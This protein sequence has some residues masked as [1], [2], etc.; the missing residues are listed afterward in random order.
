VLLITNISADSLAQEGDTFWLEYGTTSHMGLGSG[1]DYD[2]NAIEE[3]QIAGQ[4]E[5][6]YTASIIEDVPDIIAGPSEDCY[7]GETMLCTAYSS[8]YISGVITCALNEWNFSACQRPP[9]SGSGG[10]GPSP[11]PPAAP[12]AAPPTYEAP[13]EEEEGCGNRVIDSGEQCDDGNTESGDGC[14][15][16]CQLEEGVVIT[17]NNLL[18][19]KRLPATGNWRNTYG[20]NIYLRGTRDSVLS[21]QLNTNSSGS[22]QIISPQIPNGV[23]DIY[24]KGMSHLGIFMSDIRIEGN[25]SIDSSHKTILPGDITGDNFVNALD[26]SS[27]INKLYTSQLQADLNRDGIVN[28]LDI[29]IMLSSLYKSG[30]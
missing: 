30:E 18:P 5:N 14:S 6:F 2:V 7:P 27:L 20:V 3:Q 13:E 23:Y 19:L 4:G 12:P 25:T 29:G 15:S 16:T 1:E 17:F 28:A 10:P 22:G 8:N 26:I 11:A 24:L 21:A 9:T